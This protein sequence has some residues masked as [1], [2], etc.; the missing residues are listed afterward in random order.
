MKRK[1]KGVL[2]STTTAFALSLFASFTSLA[3]PL[4]DTPVETEGIATED[5]TTSD[6]GVSTETPKETQ[7]ETPEETTK[8]DALEGSP[9]Y[10]MVVAN[11]KNYVN[12]REGQSTDTAKVGVLYK[13]GVG[14]ILERGEEWTLVRSGEV[15]GYIYNEYLLFDEEAESL[16]EESIKTV[17]MVEVSALNVR[18]EPTVESSRLKQ[19]TEG[20]RLEVIEE[21]DGWLEIDLGNGSVAYV[22]T[23]YVVLEEEINEAQTIDEFT[24]AQAAKASTQTVT[25]GSSAVAASQSDLDLL[26]AIIECEA[27]GESYEGKIA[28]GAVVLNRVRSSSFPGTVSG[29]IYQSGQFS[30]AGSGK[31][32][33]VLSRGARSDCYTAA[34]DALNGANNIGGCLYFH[35]GSGSGITIGNQTFY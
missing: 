25:S 7:I 9:E 15:E 20:A 31:L 29:V 12:I 17:A 16:I 2:G 10:N 8:G 13:G 21:L 28:V 1:F 33:Q 35:A 26:A 19:V 14:E 22:C 3:G 6:G 18:T 24:E 4:S 27:G 34:Q 32:Q 30:P 11:V 5:G 23:D